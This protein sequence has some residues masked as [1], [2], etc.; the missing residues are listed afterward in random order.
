MIR[1]DVSLW[2]AAQQPALENDMTN[3]QNFTSDEWTKILES[4]ALSAVAVTAADPSGLMGLLKESFASANATISAKADPGASELVKSVVTDFETTEGRTRIREALKSRLAGA[5][6]ANVS[7]RAVEALSE[8]SALLDSKAP[9]EAADFKTWLRTIS[10]KVAD[11]A[12]EGGT[13]GF[14]GVRVSAKEKA[15]LNDIAKA[16]GI[17]A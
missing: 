7:Q 17:A 8:V 12:S 9:T 11:A 6:Q 15:T 2:R 16:L 4:V 1:R 3:K 5:N 10:S 14:G 13:L